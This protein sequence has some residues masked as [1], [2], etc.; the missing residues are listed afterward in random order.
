MNHVDTRAVVDETAQLGSGVT[1]APF[2]IVKAGAVANDGCTIGSH[3][4]IASGVRLGARVQVFSH[5]CL[6]TIPQTKPQPSREGFLIVGDDTVIREF[7]T[8]NSGSVLQD[9][10]GDGTTR[11]GA[12]CLLMAYV[13]VGHD[14]TVG[15]DVILVN[16]ATL[17]GHVVVEDFATISALVPVHQFVRIGAYS[18]VA[19]GFRAVQDV[20]PYILAAGEPLRPY[21][22]NVVGL[23][24]HGFTA[25]QFRRL[26]A[27]Y[28]LF[29]RS[30]LNTAQALSR[31]NDLEPSPERDRFVA[32]L[33]RSQRGVIR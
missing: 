25:E 1:V 32:F 9:R 3:A 27:I 6:G 8:L 11:I 12:R 22:L 33:E 19:G 2:A 29:F 16:G 4:F 30:S 24:R 17:G 21:G 10:G 26:R 13:H 28:R 31:S 7:T 15:N 20:P 5:A 23:R 14:C 18:Y